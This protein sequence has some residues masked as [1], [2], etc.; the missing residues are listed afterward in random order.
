MLDETRQVDGRSEHGVDVVVEAM[1]FGG[2]AHASI[3]GCVRA[4][5]TSTSTSSCSEE[6]RRVWDITGYRLGTAEE[7]S[8]S[9]YGENRLERV[10]TTTK[11]SMKDAVVNFVGDKARSL[12]DIAK[13]QVMEKTG[14]K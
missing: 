6:H 2:V 1:L 4:C 5:A 7:V 3:F 9:R 14:S 11:E 12:T 10:P 13:K 8:E